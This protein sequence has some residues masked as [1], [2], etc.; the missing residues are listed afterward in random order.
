MPDALI[1]ARRRAEFST[2]ERCHIRELLNDARAPELSLARCRVEPGVTTELHAL[3]VDEFY[4]VDAGSGAM[5]VGG[6]E[7]FAVGPGDAVRIPAGVSQRI[8]NS[9]HDD[10]VFQCICTPRF[11]PAAYRSLEQD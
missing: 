10:L 7:P 5:E 3:S 1:P 2:R 9:G 6:G 8:R 11:T 4:V